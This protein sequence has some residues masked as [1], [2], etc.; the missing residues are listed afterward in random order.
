MRVVRIIGF[1][2]YDLF[3]NG[4]VFSHTSNKFLKPQNNGNGYLKVHLYSSSRMVRKYLHRL[5]AEHFLEN[6]KG[7]KFIDHIDRNKN[8]NHITNLRW[9]SASENT[10]NTAGKSRYSV[11]RTLATHYTEEI[12][13][14]VRQDYV[15][16]LTVMQLHA[17]YNI[18]RQS[19]SRFVKGLKEGH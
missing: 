7:Y 15:T 8:N 10:N 6:P 11:K 12:K 19:I 18:P 1:E 17:K 9:C 14:A 2:D 16:G 3:E 13:Q 5:V 4:A